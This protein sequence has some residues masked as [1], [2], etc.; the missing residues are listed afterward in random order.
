M[1]EAPKGL[2][3]ETAVDVQAAR[4]KMIT[5]PK[6][7]QKG[8]TVTNSSGVNVFCNKCKIHWPISSAPL[9]KEVPM[10]TPRGLRKETLVE[11]DWSMADIEIGDV[12]NEQVGPKRR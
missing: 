12:T 5:C 1:A 3:G 6:C 11:P 4:E 9:A 8:R 2:P 7:G 10:S